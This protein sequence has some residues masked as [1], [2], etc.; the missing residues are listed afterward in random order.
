MKTEKKLRGIL[1]WM[2]VIAL[3]LWA[4]YAVFGYP[5]LSPEM[6]MHRAEAQ[7]LVGPSEKIAQ[8]E[9][10]YDFFDHFLL[11]ETEQG[12]C[13]Y[14]Y[15]ENYLEWDDVLTYAEKQDRITLFPVNAVMTWRGDSSENT[16]VM[17]VFAIPGSIR[18]AGARLTLTAEFSGK[19][20]EAS[21][22]AQLEQGVFFLFNPEVVGVH[23]HVRDFWYRSLKGD[24]IV[25]PGVSGAMILELF[26]RQ[27]NLIETIVTEYPAAE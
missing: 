24:P 3:S 19:H 2:L 12:Y 21:A 27:G 4:I 11:G 8:G 9:W 25:Y 13:L 10:K 16:T 6:A 15:C 5:S 18:A 26:D 7:K 17:P 1:L 23:E 22:D 14:E 20:Y